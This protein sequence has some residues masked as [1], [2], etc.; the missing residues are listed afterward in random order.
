MLYAAV[1]PSRKGQTA[2][3]LGFF[4]GGVRVFDRATAEAAREIEWLTDDDTPAMFPWPEPGGPWFIR[5]DLAVVDNRPQVVGLHLESFGRGE[6]EEG[7]PV[8]VPGPQ[9][10]TEV[11]H[12]VVR[13]LRMGQIAES[14]RRAFA[15]LATARVMTRTTD[16][17]VHAR[18]ARQLLEL[19]NRGQPR[20]RRPAAGVEQLQQVADLYREAL[21][22][23]G[24]VARKPAKY[25][26][27]R[28]RAAGLDIDAPAVRKLIARARSKQLLPPTTPRR[29][30]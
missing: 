25:V 10:L 14:A 2:D 17:A 28:L 20:K 27:Q 16:A 9:G 29:P 5:V 11:T 6:D 15:I 24:E 26:E 3:L 18:M 12:N 8:R 21:A 19:T 13:D 23:G 1:V 4:G 22:S 30:G 7:E